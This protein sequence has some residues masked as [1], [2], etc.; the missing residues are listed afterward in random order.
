MLLADA[1]C[2][3]L[4]RVSRSVHL[5]VT[6]TLGFFP[7]FI[8][9][10]LIASGPAGATATMLL[11]SP[12]A[13]LP[14]SPLGRAG[15]ASSAARATTPPAAVAAATCIAAGTPAIE[16]TATRTSSRTVAD[17]GRGVTPASQA[18]SHSTWRMLRTL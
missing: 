18:T 17:Y 15:G 6:Y 10:V 13:P 9:L 8:I 11:V 4:G 2:C 5:R 3:L 14:P 1:A 12:I 7:I 16:C